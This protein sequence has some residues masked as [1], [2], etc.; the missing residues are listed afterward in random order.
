M[1]FFNLM[2]AASFTYGGMV[3]MTIQK[4][5]NQAAA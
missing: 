1:H 4:T 5:N 3:F 2:T